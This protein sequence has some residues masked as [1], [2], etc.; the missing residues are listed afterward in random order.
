MSPTDTVKQLTR[1][2]LALARGPVAVAAYAAG[3]VKGTLEGTVH[4][5]EGVL[6]PQRDPRHTEAEP[7]PTDVPAEE[8]ETTPEATIKRPRTKP[9]E[10]T[11]FGGLNTEP[12]PPRTPGGGGEAIEHEPHAESRDVEHGDVPVRAREIESWEEEAAGELADEQAAGIVDAELAY[13]SESSAVEAA[14]EEPAPGEPLLDP[15]IAKAIRKESEI[16][17][18]AADPDKG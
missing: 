11:M 14:I 16:L 17:Q 7:T 15:S 13:T 1:T 6:H 8:E 9:G 4:V 2:G 12:A 3:V 10:R 5:V 18:K